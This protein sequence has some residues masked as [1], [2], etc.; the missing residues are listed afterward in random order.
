MESNRDRDGFELFP[1]F[2]FSMLCFVGIIHYDIHVL[3]YHI[4]FFAIL[5]ESLQISV[6]DAAMFFEVGGLVAVNVGIRIKRN[7]IELEEFRSGF[8]NHK[9]CPVGFVE[10]RGPAG[11]DIVIPCL[12]V[13]VGAV[14]VFDSL[15]YRSDLT[16]NVPDFLCIALIFTLTESITV[17]SLSI[18]SIFLS[19][20]RL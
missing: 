18:E 3:L 9:I 20:N 10:G 17:L 5:L 7:V 14:E 6:K 16:V 11:F 13:A 1:I 2:P 4:Q 8:L 19:I 15:V 12:F